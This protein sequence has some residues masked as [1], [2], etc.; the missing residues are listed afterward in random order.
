MMDIPA[1]VRP[2]FIA[3]GW[4]PDRQVTVPS[5]VPVDHP[6]AAILSEFGDLIVGT[7]GVGQECSSSDVAFGR[8]W[9][10]P[11]LVEPWSELLGSSLVSVAETD[12]GHCELY[13]DGL[14]R[15][16][17]ISM[18]HDAFWFVGQSFGEAMER[19]LL[20]RRPQPMLRPG[21][22]SVMLYGETFTADHPSIY[23]Y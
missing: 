18:I 3:A 7:N 14:G 19:L 13:V 17:G 1:T 2:L 6:A 10:V 11:T 5:E 21:Q 22:D 8:S 12:T 23:R 4:H 15:Y 16:F 9:S 20:G